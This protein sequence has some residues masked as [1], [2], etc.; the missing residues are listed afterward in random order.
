MFALPK[1]N[2]EGLQI[3]AWENIS[4]PITPPGSGFAVGK[5]ALWRKRRTDLRSYNLGPFETPFFDH[6]GKL[7]TPIIFTRGLITIHRPLST[8]LWN[9]T[10]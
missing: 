3:L 9:A 8:Q 4:P 10:D 5:P 7:V 6:G 2:P 1:M